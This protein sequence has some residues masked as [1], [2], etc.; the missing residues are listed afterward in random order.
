MAALE[1][2]ILSRGS[3][4]WEEKLR[5]QNLLSLWKKKRHAHEMIIPVEEVA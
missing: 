1:I 5:G 2:E 4:A 3:V